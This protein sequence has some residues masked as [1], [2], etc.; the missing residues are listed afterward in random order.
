MHARK[1]KQRALIEKKNNN[2]Y[3]RLSE[4]GN[5]NQIKWEGKLHARWIYIVNNL[6]RI[7]IKSNGKMNYMLDGF[8]MNNLIYKKTNWSKRNSG[9]S[10]H[11]KEEFDPI[12]GMKTN[13]SKKDRAIHGKKITWFIFQEKKKET[14]QRKTWQS[15]KHGTKN[16]IHPLIRKQTDQRKTQWY[17]KGKSNLVHLS[18]RK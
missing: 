17:M 5:S 7:Q 16:L 9:S 15:M 8:I 14:D 1:A 10:K 13:W 3:P 11:G 6:I 2:S 12:L 4:S 18:R